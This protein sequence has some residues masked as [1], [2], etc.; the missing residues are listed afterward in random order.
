MYIFRL[1]VFGNLIE[2]SGDTPGSAVTNAVRG[3]YQVYSGTANRRLQ[4]V[5][6]SSPGDATSFGEFTRNASGYA[7]WHDGTYGYFAQNGSFNDFDQ[8]TVATEGN[9]TQTGY[10]LQTGFLQ[11]GAASA[12]DTTRMLI[13]GGESNSGNTS[14]IQYTAMPVGATAQTFGALGSARRNTEGTADDTYSVWGGGWISSS[15]SNI[16]YVT[17]QTTGNSSNFGVLWQSRNDAGTV[18]DGIK[19]FFIGGYASQSTTRVSIM[20]YVTIATP[21]NA[22]D[23]GDMTAAGN[24]VQGVSG[25]AA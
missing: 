22:T 16:D 10:T 8:I 1:D 9:A 14:T 5:T 19:A 11:Y 2:Q 15:I 7:A 4:F 18:T 6:I 24:H 12:G 20:D 17:T 21:G 23:F 25:A 13:A 3:V